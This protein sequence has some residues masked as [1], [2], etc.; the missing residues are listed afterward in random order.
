MTEPGAGSNLQAIKTTAI[1]NGDHYVLNGSKTFITNG[2]MADVVVVVA[3]TNPN[4]GAKGI[5]LFVVE[6]NWEGFKKGSSLDKIGMK[7]QDT[8]ELFFND[9]KILEESLLGPEGAGFM[10]LMKSYS[11]K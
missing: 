9:L 5:S 10:A 6:A 2:Q 3:K 1:K 4:E 11:L 8:S 7:A